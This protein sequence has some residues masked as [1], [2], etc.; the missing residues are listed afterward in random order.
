MQHVLLVFITLITLPL[1]HTAPNG[2][3]S[4]GSTQCDSYTYCPAH[5]TYLFSAGTLTAGC[6]PGLTGTMTFNSAVCTACDPLLFHP[7]SI[8]NRCVPH[9][10]NNEQVQE[11]KSFISTGVRLGRYSSTIAGVGQSYISSGS[12]INPSYIFTFV[13]I[14][15]DHY[16]ARI[17]FSVY[18]YRN[19]LTNYYY[20]LNYSMD[21]TTYT[22][23]QSTLNYFSCTDIVTSPLQPHFISNLTVIW[24]N[25]NTTNL[26]YNIHGCS[27]CN[28]GCVQAGST[29]CENKYIQILDVLLMV[30]KCPTYCATCYSPT[31]CSTCTGS[32]K[33]N[34]AD[35]LCYPPVPKLPTTITVCIR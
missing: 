10:L 4:P 29:C 1:V 22:Y 25:T 20:P 32:N 21:N 23:D 16:A 8:G 6:S 14:G 3:Y 13:S 7:V 35:R 28:C 15:T 33:L 26:P 34:Y 19:E 2:I 11:Y 12:P 18:F 27:S 17:R 30:S 31:N 5:C 24:N 9:L